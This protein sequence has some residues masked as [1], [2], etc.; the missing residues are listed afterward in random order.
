MLLL[1]IILFSALMQVAMGDGKITRLPPGQSEA[2]PPM[3]QKF[4]RVD[5]I[6]TD[7]APR[8]VYQNWRADDI[9]EDD[10]E[11]GYV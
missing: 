5:L 9:D 4:H 2:D 6:A 1:V 3:R 11:E 10:D 8:Q 7:Y